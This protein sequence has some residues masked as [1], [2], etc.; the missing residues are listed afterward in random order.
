MSQIIDHHLFEEEN[1]ISTQMGFIPFPTNLTFPSLDCNQS[2]KAF[3]SIA[4]S[5]TS[6]SDS[7]SNLTQTLLTTNPQKSKEYLTSSFG[8][9]T[10]F[11]SLHGS[12]V[13]PWAILGGEVISNCMN[14]SGK[15]NGVDHRDNHLGVSTTMK[16]KKMKGR[17]KVR[18][19]RFCFKTLSTDVDV[20]DDGYKWRKYG[21]KVVKNT[22][23]PRSYY[24]CTQE[25][26]RVKKR[27]ERLAEDPR[28]VITTYEGRHVHSPSNDLEDSQTQSDNFLW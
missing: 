8:G 4:S 1:Q 7:T 10:P 16:M 17:K 11:L 20:L 27:V 13:N 21:Q 23:H 5:L 18:E 25:N 19:P 28:M 12:I 14:N 15:R 3:S 26:C 24:R 9:S 2:L 6:E 22:Q